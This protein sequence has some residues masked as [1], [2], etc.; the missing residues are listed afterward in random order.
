M[1]QNPLR[2]GNWSVQELARLR[3]LLPQ[4]GVEQTAVLLRRSADRMLT[5]ED[6]RLGHRLAAA[7]LEELEE[8]SDREGDE[9]VFALP[10]AVVLVEAA[11]DPDDVLGHARLLCDDE[12]LPHALPP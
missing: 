10:V 11:E 5:E 7:W 12:G 2:R 6:R 8:M 9:V 4:R 1:S 3:L